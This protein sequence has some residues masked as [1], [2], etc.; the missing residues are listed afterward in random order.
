MLR[1]RADIVER[2]FLNRVEIIAAEIEIAR[3]QPVRTEVGSLAAH[4]GQRSEMM[5]EQDFF[6]LRQFVRLDP[7][8][9]DFVDDLQDADCSHASRF[10]GSTVASMPSKPGSPGV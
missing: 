2:H 10:V 5:A 6:R 3:E 4:G 9:F 8:L 7:T 1:R